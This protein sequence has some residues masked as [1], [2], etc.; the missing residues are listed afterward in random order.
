MGKPVV[1]WEVGA[2]D[3]KKQS[4]FYAK[5]FGWQ[6][7]F[8]EQMGYAM[9]HTDAGHGIDGGIGPVEKGSKPY[10]TFYVEVDNMQGYLDKAVSMGAKM[11]VPVTETPM[12]TFAM[13]ADPEGNVV[14]LVKA[15]NA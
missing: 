13:F 9:M 4:E 10:V 8:D 3:P 6:G 7:H 5:L 2:K 14:G 15:E 1:H 12:V 11:M